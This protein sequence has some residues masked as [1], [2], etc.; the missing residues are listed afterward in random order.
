MVYLKTN[1]CWSAQLSDRVRIVGLKI[2]SQKREQHGQWNAV[3]NSWCPADCQLEVQNL[4]GDDTQ[5]GFH[6][7]V[8]QDSHLVARPSSSV[9]A[10]G[11]AGSQDPAVHKLIVLGKHRQ[12]QLEQ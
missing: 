1:V 6:L 11:V 2:N 8:H 10:V 12:H 5:D 9:P 7:P 3:W 4:Q